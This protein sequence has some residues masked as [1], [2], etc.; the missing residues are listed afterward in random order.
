MQIVRGPGCV[1]M[2]RELSTMQEAFQVHNAV[3]STTS[4]LV[5][6]GYRRV[7]RGCMGLSWGCRMSIAQ[8]AV[9]V[10][11]RKGGPRIWGIMRMS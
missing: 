11:W 1:A 10:I 6:L 9:Q 5:S 8:V 2:A 3:F 7:P 4:A